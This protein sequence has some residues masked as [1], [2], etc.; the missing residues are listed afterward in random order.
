MS[1]QAQ[2][3]RNLLIGV[4]VCGLLLVGIGATFSLRQKLNAPAPTPTPTDA[5]DGVT[6]MDPPRQLDNFT[7]PASTGKSMSLSDFQGK[8]TMLFFGYT[9]CPDFCPITLAHWTNIRKQLGSDAS[10]VNFLFISVDGGRDTPDVIKRYL[11]RFDPSF[12]GMTG[13]DATLSKIGGAYGLYYELHKEEGPNYSVDHTTNSYL[14]DPKNQMIVVFDY[15][16][17]EATIT[18]T[19]QQAIA[20]QNAA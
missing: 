4:I 5:P 13:D 9:H 7:L 17:P 10:D 20:A 2:S 3:T 1:Q 8:F 12:I 11:S 6:P 15:D 14:L 18:Q 16:T 19:I